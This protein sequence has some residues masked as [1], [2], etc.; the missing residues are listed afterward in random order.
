M[1]AS[2]AAFGE[3]PPIPAPSLAAVDVDQAGSVR[4]L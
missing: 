1:S 3:P 4:K 2:E